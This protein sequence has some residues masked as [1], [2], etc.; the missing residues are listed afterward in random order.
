MRTP[1]PAPLVDDPP[2]PQVPPYVQQHC[3]TSRANNRYY[4]CSTSIDNTTRQKYTTIIRCLLKLFYTRSFALV[5][6]VPTAIVPL[7]ACSMCVWY[8]TWYL[9]N[10]QVAILCCGCLVRLRWF[11]FRRSYVYRSLWRLR[12]RDLR[13]HVVYPKSNGTSLTQGFFFFCATPCL[14]EFLSTRSWAFSK[15]SMS[16]PRLYRPGD[17]MTRP[18]LSLRMLETHNSNA[19]KHF[20]SFFSFCFVVSS[21]SSVIII[22][23]A[24]II[25]ITVFIIF[26]D[27]HI[28]HDN[29]RPQYHILGRPCSIEPGTYAIRSV[30]HSIPHQRTPMSL[31]RHW[32][33]FC[34]FRL[35]SLVE[36][37]VR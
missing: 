12:S 1:P 20:S 21:S 9:L 30:S 6:L 3:R 35:Y 8:R 33:V 31:K 4:T 16:S 25:I 2:L 15:K 28:H 13:L 29:H 26:S 37:S 17:W 10:V 5:T 32:L 11:S 24:F 27:H 7:Y 34:F 22:V 36:A 14:F 23:I 18:L 19:G